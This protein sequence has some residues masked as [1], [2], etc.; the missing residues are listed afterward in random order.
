LPNPYLERALWSAPA[1]RSGDGALACPTAFLMQKRCPPK[2]FGVA[3]A[4]HIFQQPALHYSR[5]LLNYEH[6]SGL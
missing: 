1:E 3:T 6:A 2:A 4:L 5:G